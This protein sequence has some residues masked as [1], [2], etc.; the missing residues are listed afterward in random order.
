VRL[1]SAEGLSDRLRHDPPGA[2]LSGAAAVHSFAVRSLPRARRFPLIL[3]AS[4]HPYR[5][6]PWSMPRHRIAELQRRA[7]RMKA[8]AAAD[9][10]IAVADAVAEPL[11]EAFPDK[12]IQVVHNQVVTDEFIHGAGATIAYP[13]PDSPAV[14]LI[15][16][17]GRLAVAKDFPTLLRAFALVRRRREVRLA[18]LGSGP[19][20]RR[21]ELLDMASKLQIESDFALNDETDHVAAWL[22]RA[23]L[24]VSSSLWEGAPAV[25]IEA[26]AMGAPV[27]ATDSVGAAREILADPELGALVPPRRPRLMAEA[28]AEWLDRPIDQ[29]RLRAA[30]APYRI[31]PTDEYLSAIDECAQRRTVR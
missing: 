20:A 14:P 28:I 18:L 7:K 26:L 1:I 22:S 29:E 4:S 6:F 27:I 5:D 25:I 8:Y 12:C 19:A 16:G 2:F 13:W 10:I 3:R 24:L 23:K 11:R 31:D 17:I 21:R 9:L 30:T 15:V